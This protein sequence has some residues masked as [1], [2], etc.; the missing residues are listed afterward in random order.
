MPLSFTGVETPDGTHGVSF[1]AKDHNG[2]HLAV[3][4]SHYVLQDYDRSQIE[5]MASDKYDAGK[6]EANGTVVVR[7]KD[8]T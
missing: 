2:K 5:Q 1:R 4:V 8:F 3:Q 6:I 7:T